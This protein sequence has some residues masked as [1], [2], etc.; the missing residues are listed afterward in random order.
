[1][2]VGLGFLVVGALAGRPDLALLGVAPVLMG[3]RLLRLRPRGRVD[4]RGSAAVSEAGRLSVDARV[5]APVYV[6]ALRIRASLPGSPTH[7]A[8][9]AVDG[10]RTLVAA[11]RSLRTGPQPAPEL[12]HLG[13]G[14]GAG[15]GGEVG[16]VRLPDLLVAPR[17]I[18]LR[19]GPLP[20]RLRGIAGTHEARTRL[21]EGGSLRDVHPFAPGDRLARIDW[22]TTARRSPQLQ[23]LYVR[24]TNALAEATVTLVVDSRDDVGPDPTTW[25]DGVVPTADRTSLDLAREAAATLAQHYLATG[26]RVAVEDLGRRR[27]P[28]RPGAGR[29]HLDRVLHQLARMAPEGEPLQRVRAPQITAGSLVYVIST[30]LDPQAVLVAQQWHAA[31]HRVVAIDVLPRFAARRLDAR[32]RL[33][34]RVVRIRREDRLA[35]LAATG[36]ACVAWADGAAAALL[37]L[38][39]Q[40][41]RR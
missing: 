39:R 30:F 29:R 6:R 18:P 36:I 14:P 21:G 33:A 16:E 25:R 24:R 27:R 19:E 28:V 20:P 9:V 26:D 2:A 15:S 3:E 38:A 7:E 35:E 8:V 10:E 1:M 23:Q 5:R 13:L 31:G 4:V 37:A 41:R 34:L 22:R 32:Q 17:A 40:E 11:T 12:E